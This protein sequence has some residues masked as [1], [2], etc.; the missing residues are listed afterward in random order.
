[1]SSVNSPIPQD[2][3]LQ[4]ALSHVAEASFYATVEPASA[5]EWTDACAMHR[6]WL[7]AYVRFRGPFAGVMSCRLPR[8]TARDLAAA[9]LGLPEEELEPSASAVRDFAGELANMLCGRWLTVSH[10]RDLFNLEAPQVSACEPA[11]KGWDQALV[12]GAPV[13]LHIA[14]GAA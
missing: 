5:D 13:A 11:G 9:F 12:N 6:D 14:L 10:P 1:M 8:T 3:D 2:A 7:E 4:R